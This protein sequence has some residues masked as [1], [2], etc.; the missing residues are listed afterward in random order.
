MRSLSGLQTR[1]CSCHHHCNKK[2]IRPKQIVNKF[3]CRKTILQFWHKDIL[4]FRVK[5]LGVNNYFTGHI[6]V[7]CAILQ[8]LFY[9]D[10]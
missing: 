3:G 4:W 2:F 6:P 1:P 8:N 10:H 9:D 5:F 7:H